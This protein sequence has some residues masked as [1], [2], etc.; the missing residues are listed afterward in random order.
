VIFDSDVDHDEFLAH[1][2]VLRKS[3][4]YPWGSGETPYQRGKDM[5][6]HIKD[7]EDKG[8]SPVEIA[9]AFSTDEVKFTTTDLR[10]AKTIAKARIDAE[11]RA[12]AVRLKDAGNSNVAIG[13]IMGR[14][15]SSIRALLKPSEDTKEAILL[16]TAG[17][18]KDNMEKSGGFLDIGKGTG[19]HLGVSPEKLA[20][21]VAMLK[22]EGYEVFY[23]PVNQLGTGK[24]T[25][26]K[27]LAPPGTRFPDV[28]NHPE[29]IKSIATYSEDGG[30]TYLDVKPPVAVKPSRVAVRYAEDGGDQK[31]GVI[32]LRR[33]VDDLSLGSSRYA[34]VRI[35]V[36]ND[37]YL[38][39]MAMYSD[40]VPDGY[41]MIFNT[42]KTNTGDKLKAMKPIKKDANTGEDTELPF[43]S[44]VRQIN[45]PG[46]DGKQHQSPLNIVG[47]VKKDDDGNDISYSGEEGGWSKWSKSLSSQFLSKQSPDLAR[48]QLS[49]AYDRKKAE[50]DEINSLTNPVIKKKL[51][52]SYADG[53]D[54]A[55][56]HLKA[57]GLPRTA[58]H[59]ILPI[60]S[61]KDNEIYAPNYNNGERVV[62]I[63]HPHGGTFEIPELVVN[64]R[65]R[66]ANRLIK[67]AKDA[68]GINA[69]VAGRLSGA[70]FDGDTVL[71][72]PN[73][74][75][76]KGRVK[77]APPLQGLKG[78]DPQRAHP[79]FDGMKT[80]D[81]GTW[82]AKLGKP[83]F[84]IDPKTGKPKSPN[85]Q[86]KQLKMGDISNLI[87]DMTIQGAPNS[88]L[89]RAVRHSMVV[90][91][92][93]KHS[94]DFRTSAKQNGIAELKKTYQ[95]GA[96]RGAATLISRA[97]SEA[98]PADRKM[99]IDPA[100]GKRVWEYTGEQ[101]TKKNGEVVDKPWSQGKS[102]KM[103][104]ANDARELLSR[105]GGTLMEHVYADHANKLKALGDSARKATIETPSIKRNPSAAKAYAPEVKSLA[106]K[107]D[108]AQRNAPRERQ[109]QILAGTLVKARI[110]ANP[111]LDKDGIKKIKSAA[112]NEARARMGA[113]KPAIQITD[114][115]WSAVQAGAVTNNMLKSILDNADLDQV[116]Q[117]ATPREVKAIAPAKVTRAK[118]LLARGY[119]YADVAAMLGVPTS[120][121][122]DYVN[123]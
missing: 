15:E 108:L 99:R 49:L 63:R 22:D 102:T 58:N 118:S 46:K 89:A 59:V 93:E 88:E 114:K 67:Q 39:G 76:G 55:A 5:L 43:G 84:P 122:H 36:G 121:L 75:S 32:E 109:A 57:A 105:D 3:G 100:T 11:D 72:I 106:E 48:E 69:N 34:Q 53:I 61:L 1:Y 38:K 16:A 28:I 66:E 35:K 110:E 73:P 37:H 86:A 92:A 60:N 104:E 91:D 112:L 7:L 6:A 18:L 9:R 65:N 40:D 27:V 14:N 56:N 87:T 8:F 81:G 79:P 2:G 97:K 120:T 19:N 98:R 96:T 44:I 21:S 62:L 83:V 10:N 77:S 68:V 117:L 78:F 74:E 51:L 70:D 82:D 111:D 94:L 42:N 33:G 24:N 107:L 64:N 25:T 13:E 50:L 103:F 26:T 119:D 4:R 12:R 116:K 90:I 41:D 85:K 95:G 54:S 71:V 29:K 30:R 52:E 123:G 31:D 47:S 115:E 20:V 23:V 45:Y 80:I 101:I 113:K 17:T